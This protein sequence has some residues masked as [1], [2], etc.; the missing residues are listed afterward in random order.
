MGVRELPVVGEA[1]VLP[2]E[3]VRAAHERIV[4]ASLSAGLDPMDAEDLAQDIFLSFWRSRQTAQMLTVSWM[5]AV[6]INF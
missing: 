4:R 2:A 3:A 6:T 5:R 1:S